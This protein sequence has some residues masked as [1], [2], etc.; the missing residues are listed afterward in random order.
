MYMH[1]HFTHLQL[2]HEKINSQTKFREIFR[3]TLNSNLPCDIT[4]YSE[5]AIENV[6]NTFVRKICNTWIQEFL[7]ATKQQF[8]T[9]K[10]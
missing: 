8:A 9:K 10:D 4:S 1:K 5:D 6:Y 7:S 3:E 2:A